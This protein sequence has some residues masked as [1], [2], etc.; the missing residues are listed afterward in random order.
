MTHDQDRDHDPRRWRVLALL[1]VA[2]LL[3]MSVWF[4][5]SAVAPVL[6]VRWSLSSGQVAWLTTMVQ[7]GFVAGT[8]VAAVLNLADVIPS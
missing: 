4:T 7:F 3:G 6:Q 8:T 5:A 2:V 1:S